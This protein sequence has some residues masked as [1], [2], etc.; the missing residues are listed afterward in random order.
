M[1]PRRKKAAKRK[2]KLPIEHWSHSSLISFLRNPLTWYKRYVEKIY[3]LPRGPA[4]VVGIAGHLALERFYTGSSKE[5]AI[6]AG[7]ASVQNFRDEELNFGVATTKKA[8]KAK[9]ASMER[10]YLQAINFYLAR[11]PRHRVVGVE[12]RGTAYL[13]H[14]PLPL[15]AISDLVVESPG[16]PGSLDIVDHKFVDSFS[17]AGADKSLFM[18]Q[19]MFNYYTVSEAYGKPVRRFI[20]IECK[21]T[22]NKDGRSQLKKYILDYADA[23]E[24][25][26]VFHRLIHDATSELARDRKF[27]PNPSDM[28]EGEHS[29]DLYKLGLIDD[30]TE[31]P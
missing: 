25:F 5:D 1:A 15:K 13:P 31:E 4:A 22:K 18:L 27:L 26:Q 14:L 6:A 23:S 7:L 2:K 12:L 11:P 24:A 10:E 9:R 21:K 8:K 19:A 16:V 17:K 30:P 28:F 20:V 29:F 3:D